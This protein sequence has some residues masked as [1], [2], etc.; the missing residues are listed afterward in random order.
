MVTWSPRAMQGVYEVRADEAGSA[1]HE[2]AHAGDAR[3]AARGHAGRAAGTSARGH[4]G[5]W[6]SAA[7]VPRVSDR[8]L[9][10]AD[11]RALCAPPCRPAPRPRCWPTS[12]CRACSPGGPRP[13][14]ST[15]AAGAATRSTSSGRRTP[16][17]RWLGLDLEGSREFAER[18]RTDA[19]LRA[20][21]GRTLPCA[22]RERRRRVLQAGARARR[23]ARP[24]AG[25]RRARAAPRRGV[26]RGP[27]RT[28][29][30]STAAPSR[31]TR[32]TG[33]SSLLERAGLELEAVLPGIDGPTLIARR[34]ARGSRRFDRWWSRRS[35]LNAAVDGAGPPARARRRGPQHAEAAVLRA[36]RVRRAAP[37]EPLA[38]AGARAPAGARRRAVAASSSAGS[39]RWRA[40][41]ARTNASST[42]AR[43]AAG[44]RRPP[45]RPWPGPRPPRAA[46]RRPRGPRARGSGS[47][48]TTDAAKSQP[49]LTMRWAVPTSFVRP[50]AFTLCAPGQYSPGTAP[51][52]ASTPSDR[53]APASSAASSAKRVCTPVIASASAIAR[54]STTDSRW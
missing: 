24:A 35:P 5:R 21:D 48:T 4:P 40:P 37:G 42:A 52:R 9:P 41:K 19:D 18:T 49:P 29:S 44:P 14:W 2:S 43:P 45:P 36:L 28:W 22:G 27:P 16:A 38:R 10:G 34:L 26:R 31:T 51:T 33:S 50:P 6:S 46:R 12:S 8:R 47:R 54:S 25:R 7:T 1:G 32:P 15:W 3:Y 13:R 39:S 17:V 30:R 11:L 23:A 53:S 20:F